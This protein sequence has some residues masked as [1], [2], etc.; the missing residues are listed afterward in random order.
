MCELYHSCG[1]GIEGQMTGPRNV[2][3]VECLC[4]DATD[5]N[6]CTLSVLNDTFT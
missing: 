4:V 2:E 5:W 1:K 6:N 3:F